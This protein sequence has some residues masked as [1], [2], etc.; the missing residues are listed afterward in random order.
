M[1]DGL[2]SMDI[3][4]H[5]ENVYQTFS[6]ACLTFDKSEFIPS[7]DEAYDL[8]KSILS[9][10]M[11]KN[12]SKVH[13]MML[14]GAIGTSKR[15]VECETRV[16]KQSFCSEFKQMI[17]SLVGIIGFEF[18]SFLMVHFG[19]I[20]MAKRVLNDMKACKSYK[21]LY[22][23][24]HIM[25]N[26]FKSVPKS[27][28]K[29]INGNL[30]SQ[31]EPSKPSRA[32]NF[33]IENDELSDFFE[34]L[35]NELE[36]HIKSKNITK[37]D[38]NKE[39][40]I[41]NLSQ[42]IDDIQSGSKI[43]DNLNDLGVVLGKYSLAYDGSFIKLFET[44][45]RA[46]YAASPKFNGSNLFFLN[47]YKLHEKYIDEEIKIPQKNSELFIRAFETYF[48][49]VY[50]T[51]LSTCLGSE[52]SADIKKMNVSI[53]FGIYT[54]LAKITFSLLVAVA[55][56]ITIDRCVS[57]M[58]GKASR[59]QF[60]QVFQSICT[61]PIGIIESFTE[62]Q[63][64]VLH[65]ILSTEKVIN[66]TKLKGK[67]IKTTRNQGRIDNM[68]SQPLICKEEPEGEDEIDVDLI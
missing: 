37:Y 48:T 31:P 36:D 52:F 33:M 68:I 21:D 4:K 41:G 44:L 26:L 23:H 54:S 3:P 6:A 38:I 58:N 57:Q 63:L 59:V 17:K 43:I 1:E 39:K 42:M 56:S 28:Y 8:V 13:T 30:V 15:G 47:E 32:V 40:I 55:K 5:L 14:S 16:K 22:L 25:Y 11:A 9:V 62:S 49:N 67:Q 34:R 29:F 51:A 35:S 66:T 60:Q 46:M 45:Y 65:Y 50:K 20:V 61:L 53:G 2:K 19:T 10:I 24:V 7:G 64:V 18:S 27:N 12:S